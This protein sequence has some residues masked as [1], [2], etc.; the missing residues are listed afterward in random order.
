[1]ARMRTPT[2]AQN[3]GFIKSS[4]GEPISTRNVSANDYLSMIF[5][6]KF[7]QFFE[8]CSRPEFLTSTI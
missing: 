6:P 8:D 1:M 2:R 3:I 5:T 4:S 7:Y